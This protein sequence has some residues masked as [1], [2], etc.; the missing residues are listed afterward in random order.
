MQAAHKPL[1]SFSQTILA[2]TPWTNPSRPSY[3]LN[4]YVLRRNFAGFA[5][6][7]RLSSKDANLISEKLVSALYTAFPGGFFF[8][9]SELTDKH[10]HLLFEH[11]FL[12][13]REVLNSNGGIFFDL[14][15][16]T[17]AI[18]HLEDHLTLFFHDTELQGEK[19]VEQ[20]A[21]VEEKIGESIPFAYHDKFGYITSSALTLG[22]GLT[23]EGIIHA[24]AINYLQDDVKIGDNVLIHGLHTEKD[25]LHNLVICS[26]KYTLGMSEKNIAK[27]V[28]DTSHS[29]FDAEMMAKQKLRKTPSKELSNSILKD[30]GQ[31]LFCKSLQFHEA[32]ALA[33]SLD[34]GSSLGILESASKTLYFDVFFSCRRAHLEALY[35]EDSLPI[36]EKRALLCKEKIK[37]IK[38]SFC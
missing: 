12:A 15:S 30:Y 22:T 7:E 11:L 28:D 19:I 31:I 3:P 38:P 1:P 18:I 36:E 35:E 14:A 2:F 17:I 10:F 16:K 34:L 13:N 6:S 8:S 37:D 21:R 32:L 25:V 20:I 5:F 4:R 27:Y 24:P 26:N 23:K 29:I 33:S 9:S